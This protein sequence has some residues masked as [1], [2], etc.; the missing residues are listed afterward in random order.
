MEAGGLASE[1]EAI[2][3]SSMALTAPD[4]PTRGSGAPHPAAAGEGRP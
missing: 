4:W 1:Q 2:S 3:A